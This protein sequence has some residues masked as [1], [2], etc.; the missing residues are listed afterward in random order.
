[1]ALPYSGRG[2]GIGIGKETTWA[3]GV[4]RSAW[5]KAVNASLQEKT[6]RVGTP[7]LVHSGEGIFLEHY[8]SRVT[9]GG[10]LESLGT[11]NAPSFG[12]LLWAAMGD[13]ATT[14]AGPNYTHTINPSATLPSLTMEMIRGTGTAEV[15]NGC[16]C[17]SLALVQ[18]PN[19]VLRLRTSW[20]GKDSGGRVAAGTPSYTASPSRILHH[21]M[22]AISWNSLNFARARSVE[23]QINNNLE[24]RDVCGS[25][26]TDE[27]D[28]A[29]FRDVMIR[30]QLL[31]D[32]DA[33]VS[34]MRA[35]TISD[36]EVLWTGTTS[37]ETFKFT[38]HNAIVED[39]TDPISGPGVVTQNVSLRGYA[40]GSDK[41]LQFVLVNT[42]AGGGYLW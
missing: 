5:V 25:K 22:G 36:L 34:G 32:S 18:A 30:L 20:I 16:K 1:M 9:A 11:Y 38:A 26:Y 14:G 2:T 35:G 33:F 24:R 23:V 7:H 21:E 15:F 31:W 42:V 39:A 37:P 3:T 41:G 19:D 29:G 40:D 27:P 28:Y 17:S 10:D 4:A 13:A 12:D 6:E 8:L